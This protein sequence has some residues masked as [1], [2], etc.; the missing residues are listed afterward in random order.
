[1]SLHILPNVVAPLFH[2]RRRSCV[3]VATSSVA[4]LN[5]LGLGAQPPTP[6]WGLMLA[7]GR[8]YM[9][10]LLVARHLSGARQSW[11]PR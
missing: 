9:L 2:L 4:S 5:F 8:D 6:E 3:S 11:P 10:R 7:D 1:M